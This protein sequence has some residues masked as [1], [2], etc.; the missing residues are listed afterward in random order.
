VARHAPR[1]LR[2]LPST[3]SLLRRCAR[4][5]WHVWPQGEKAVGPRM[6]PHAIPLIRGS[7]VHSEESPGALPREPPGDSSGSTVF[8]P[9]ARR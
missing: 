9:G 6:A 7:S 2:G 3:R 5:A 4:P 8:G 1:A